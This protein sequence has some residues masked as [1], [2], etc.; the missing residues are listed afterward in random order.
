MLV[1]GTVADRFNRKKVAVIAIGGEVACGI[2]LAGYALTDPTEVWPLFV[3]AFVYGIAAAFLAPATRPMPPMVA[4]D[5]RHS[6]G[7]RDVLGH[8]DR[9]HHPRAGAV[10]L[11]VRV[12]PGGRLRRVDGADHRSPAS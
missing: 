11:A 6:E 9:R 7:G 1:T 8:V 2:A 5:G 4:P 10:R 12:G 3:I